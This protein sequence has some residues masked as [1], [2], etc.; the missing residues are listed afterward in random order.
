M[1]DFE[2]PPMSAEEIKKNGNKTQGL[3]G[4]LNN[5]MAIIIKR[6]PVSA[7]QADRIAKAAAKLEATSRSLPKK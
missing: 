2:Q 6:N 4:R 7:D 3:I 5:A 1:Q